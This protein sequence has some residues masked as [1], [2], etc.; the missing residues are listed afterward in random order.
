MRSMFHVKQAAPTTP[1]IGFTPTC[2]SVVGVREVA[3]YKS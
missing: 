3:P 2:G 1:R